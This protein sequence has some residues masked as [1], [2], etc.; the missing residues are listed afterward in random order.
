M[1]ILL[2]NFL[3][4]RLTSL[5]LRVATQIKCLIQHVVWSVL[6]IYKICK[7]IYF[8]KKYFARIFSAKRLPRTLQ[9]KRYSCKSP[10]RC[11]HNL[12]YIDDYLS[13]TSSCDNHQCGKRSDFDSCVWLRPYFDPIPV[14]SGRLV[15][16][17]CLLLSIF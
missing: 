5:L 1:K 14:T 6:I 13:S 17:K 7:K 10:Q 4:R 3:G 2:R 8:S 11:I 16:Q 12:C 9:P 15:G